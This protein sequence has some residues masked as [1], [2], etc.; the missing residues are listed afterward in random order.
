MRGMVSIAP[1]V[2]SPTSTEGAT[3]APVAMA[4]WGTPP[5]GPTLAT[6]R[7]NVA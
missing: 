5:H 2:V 7:Q 3:H 4:R 6:G 1:E